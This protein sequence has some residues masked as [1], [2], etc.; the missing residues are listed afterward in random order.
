MQQLKVN[1]DEQNIGRFL[2]PWESD[3]FFI[4]R[5]F[6]T[7]PSYS[8]KCHHHRSLSFFHGFLTPARKKF[9]LQQRVG[10]CHNE[11]YILN[12]GPSSF[13]SSSWV[14]NQCRKSFLVEQPKTF[15][16]FSPACEWF[17]KTKQTKKIFLNILQIRSFN[18][19]QSSL[20]HS[21]A[22]ALFLSKYIFS[23]ST[24]IFIWS[25]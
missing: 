22:L 13:N 17:N 21:L 5:E 2:W 12:E 9:W 25:P 23:S 18:A 6:S 8:G 3:I 10:F 24:S 16:K 11:S 7:R 1:K 4:L 19:F 15:L 14:E 20:T